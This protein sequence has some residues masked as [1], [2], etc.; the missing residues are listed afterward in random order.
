MKHDPLSAPREMERQRL[1]V[2]ELRTQEAKHNPG[3]ITRFFSKTGIADNTATDVLRIETT[4][5][6]GSNDAGTYAVFFHFLI[7]HGAGAT[8]SNNAAKSLT[9]HF[10][11]AVKSDGATGVNSAVSEISETA[12]A[13]T[14]SLNRDIGTVTV[15][16]QENTEY[17]ND[18]QITVDLTGVGVDTAAVHGWVQVLW[19][20]FSTPPVLTQ[21]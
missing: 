6:S 14:N 20:G 12:S 1:E 3:L 5:E 19:Q 2:E 15:T 18:V 4:N 11:R 13:A 9:G 7:T 17:Q 21:L 8:A 10:V 16:I